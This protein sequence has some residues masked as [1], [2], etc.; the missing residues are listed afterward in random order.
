[1]KNTTRLLTLLIALLMLVTV[2]AA[3]EEKKPPVYVETNDNDDTNEEDTENN[4]VYVPFDTLYELNVLT[5]ISDWQTH[6][7]DSEEAPAGTINAALFERNSFIEEVLNIDII[8]HPTPHGDR[9]RITLQMD[10]GEYN[11]DLIFGMGNWWFYPLLTKGYLVDMGSIDEMDLTASCWDQNAVADLSVLNRNYAVTGDL[12]CAALDATSMLLMNREFLEDYSELPD[13]TELTLDG[14]WTYEEYYKMIS[15]VSAENGDEVWD[16]EDTYGLTSTTAVYTNLVISCG[17]SFFAKNSNDIPQLSMGTSFQE[18][19]DKM[20]AN[21]YNEHSFI[22]NTTNGENPEPYR[23]VFNNGHALF[24]GG[25][26]GDLDHIDLMNSGL[27]AVSPVPF[28]KFTADQDRFYTPVNFQAELMMMPIGKDPA[29]VGYIAQTICEESTE[30]LRQPYYEVILKVR[31]VADP[32]D[33]DVLDIIYGSRS[34]DLGQISEKG[35]IRVQFN[36]MCASG[37]SDI[38]S[39]IQQYGNTASRLLRQMYADI[40]D[41]LGIE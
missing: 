2:F 39:F 38:A 40:K 35:E 14:T 10:A 6:I 8:E 31:R 15:A 12:H 9:D 11:Y 27:D 19:F 13:P 23:Y 26:V 3:C 4:K 7:F 34:Y 1:M 22:K 36:S 20:L 21:V 37:S 17:Q 30:M 16:K 5:E 41:K 25:L 33:P 28:P 32:R 18:N 29:T 24:M